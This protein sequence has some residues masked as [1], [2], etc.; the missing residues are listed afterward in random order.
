MSSSSRVGQ[1]A[2]AE[3]RAVRE[4]FLR[5]ECEPQF[6]R[7]GKE[8]TRTKRDVRQIKNDQS[9]IQRWDNLPQQKRNE[10][11]SRRSSENKMSRICNAK[12]NV[13]CF[14]PSSNEK[15]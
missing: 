11:R 9:N 2:R 8:V 13:N 6:S 5:W 15:K 14:S 3:G 1:R 10:L 7:A 12:K 4:Q